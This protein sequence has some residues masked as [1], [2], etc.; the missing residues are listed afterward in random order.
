MSRTICS[1]ALISASASAIRM[2]ISWP[3]RFGVPRIKHATRPYLLDEEESQHTLSHPKMRGGQNGC[4]RRVYRPQ[5]KIHRMPTCERTL[6]PEKHA[7]RDR[8]VAWHEDIFQED[9]AAAGS[10]QAEGVPGIVDGDVGARNRNVNLPERPSSMIWRRC[11]G[12]YAHMV[13]GFLALGTSFFLS[14][15]HPLRNRG[16]SNRR[17]IETTDEFVRIKS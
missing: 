1:A 13:D 7:G 4:E 2:C 3:S 11:S 6:A 5:I 17:E 8:P 16:N 9:V 12:A 15:Q 10:T 14:P